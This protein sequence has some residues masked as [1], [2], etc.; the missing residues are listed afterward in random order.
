MVS[1]AHRPN[2]GVDAGAWQK[3]MVGFVQALRAVGGIDSECDQYRVHQ[4]GVE[5]SQYGPQ[6]I[7]RS[8][9]TIV[10]VNAAWRER[11]DG[12]NKPT[13]G[14][15]AVAEVN[16]LLGIFARN[17]DGFRRRVLLVILPG[18]SADDVPNRLSGLHRFP[19]TEFTLAGM[20]D[21]LR[22]LTGQPAHLAPPVGPLPVLP[23]RTPAAALQPKSMESSATKVVAPAT[24]GDAG[25]FERRLDQVGEGV[26]VEQAAFAQDAGGR[27]GPVEETDAWPTA[28]VGDWLGTTSPW[29]QGLRESQR[30]VAGTEV[31]H[32]RLLAGPGTGK[33]HVL[34]RRAQFLLEAGLAPRGLLA[35]TFTRAAAAEMRVR[36][37]ERL[38]ARAERVRVATLHS[39][40]LSLL[41]RCE[42][43]YLP[44][45]LRIIGDWEERHVV[46]EE[47]A[48]ALNRPVKK[49]ID[50][51]TAL[52]NDW[53]TLTSSGRDWVDG[54]ADPAFVTAWRAH[55]EVYGYTLRSEL[56][57]QL[58]NELRAD[59]GLSPAD[60]PD[61]I[62]VDEYQDLNR[63]DLS[64]I[65]E[66]A[67]RCEA[68]VF[69][70]GDDDQSIYSFRAA[71]PAGIR[72]FVREYPG[73]GD[74]MLEECLRCGSE[75]TGLASWVI[76]QEPGRVDKQLVSVTDDPG[77][78]T[79]VRF[80]DQH[81]EAA[82]IADLVH[83]A[84]TDGT[85]PQDILV[86]FHSDRDGRNSR[87]LVEAVQARGHRTYL[88]RRADDED[89]DLVRLQ[90]YLLLA[91]A[92]GQ[93]RVDDLA[94]RS[95]VEL[96]GNGIGETT[97]RAVR[98]RATSTRV[99]WAQALEAM[100]DPLTPGPAKRTALL[101]AADEILKTARAVIPQAE[102]AM[103]AWIERVIQLLATD[104]ATVDHVHQLLDNGA[105][106][107]PIDDDAT[108]VDLSVE[109]DH[110]QQ[111]LSALHGLA[112][113]LPASVEGE[114][115][116]TT[117]HGAKG[118]TAS[119]VFVCQ[120]E[121][122]RLP[123]RAE[124]EAEVHE[125]RR[126]LYVSLTRARRD[127]Y[128]SYCA[129]RIGAQSYGRG[130]GADS[131]RSLTRFLR[132]AR[133]QARTVAELLQAPR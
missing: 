120:L 68:H 63:C 90:Q 48:D 61:V 82:G 55:R 92:L 26:T 52:A 14:A 118:L 127:L 75:I 86:L 128:L 116:V 72:D 32:A 98:E 49:I 109:P 22:T 110:L 46:V 50:D 30:L 58:R 41:L 108:A 85:P 47:L 24:A 132:D 4:L 89:L 25:P 77:A 35:L 8:R 2:E 38:G 112:D 51:L 133:L 60:P 117:M 34:V 88:P 29:S 102:E 73:A 69:A 74:M 21:L 129:Q 36:L 1:W 84:I 62:L 16:E 59:P 17:Q 65:V 9:H 104:P 91:Q 56:V 18:A 93:Q 11:F 124:T 66:L 126:L 78:V 5:W 114:V 70:A 57:Y 33:T 131:R 105:A 10:A 122:E 20:E 37:A 100:R 113:A 19:I 12:D 119:T 40:A 15:G 45:P 130:G 81:D 103:D 7:R 43:A 64:A 101:A 107:D 28:S 23:P 39:Y 67:R 94:L 42:S 111:L 121:D 53:D 54:R 87:D 71:A 80:K 27:L 125:A 97:L 83:A 6:Q 44:Q 13:E 96:E 76:R 95:L 31:G 106:L 115:T 79:L 99:S 123:G 3:T